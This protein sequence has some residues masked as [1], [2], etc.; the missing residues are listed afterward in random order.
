MSPRFGEVWFADLGRPTGH[1]QAGRRPA[2]VVS[3]DRFNEL[4]PGVAIVVPVTR[5]ERAYPTR[6]AVP[7]G[8][9]GLRVTSWAAVE[10][11]SSVSVLRLQDHLGYVDAGVMGLIGRALRLVLD[12]P[13]VA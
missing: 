12:L 7:R 10:H 4:G 5:V 13:E 6:V 8:R 9:S 3:S 2:I 11:L 1:E